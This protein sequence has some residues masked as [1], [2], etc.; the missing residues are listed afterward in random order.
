[1]EQQIYALRGEFLSRAAYV[2]HMLTWV[3]AQ[4]VG[5]RDHKQGFPWFVRTPISATAK[6]NLFESIHGGNTMLPT[7]FCQRFRKM[8][9]VRNVLA[10][11]WAGS[12][13]GTTRGENLPDDL[14]DPDGLGEWIVEAKFFETWMSGMWADHEVGI[15]PPISADDFADWPL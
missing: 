1:M 10:H 7:D 4:D 3:I 12:F 2:E 8:Q 6:I 9:R 5:I 13:S 11:S 14:D 15:L